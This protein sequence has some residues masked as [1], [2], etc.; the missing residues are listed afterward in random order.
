MPELPEVETTR[1]GIEPHVC[2]QRIVSIR[3]RSQL[4]WP[5]PAEVQQAV[6]AVIA[7]D[8]RAKYLL[9]RTAAG[10]VVLHLGMSA[11]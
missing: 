2:G 4:R 11:A 6:G 9:L 7:V 5:V 3:V 10:S 8:R 1:R